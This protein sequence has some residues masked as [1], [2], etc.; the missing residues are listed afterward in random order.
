MMCDCGLFFFMATCCGKYKKKKKSCSCI[1][2]SAL[3]AWLAIHLRAMADLFLSCGDSD[4]ER[5]DLS[6]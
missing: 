5:H 3:A 2:A 6:I 4:S 1:C